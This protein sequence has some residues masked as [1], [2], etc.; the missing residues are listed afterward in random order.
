M[1]EDLGTIHTRDG[2]KRFGLITKKS[3]GRKKVEKTETSRLYP[4]LIND[5]YGPI[6]WH[7]KEQLYI[8]SRR[9]V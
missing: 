8:L 3:R 2:G 7:I 9:L 5:I 6:N 4:L 1:P